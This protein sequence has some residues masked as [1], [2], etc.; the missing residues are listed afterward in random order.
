MRYTQRNTVV[1]GIGD[2]SDDYEYWL[3]FQKPLRPDDQIDLTE[4]ELAEEITKQLDTEHKNFPKNLV[5]YSFKDYGYVPVSFQPV[6]LIK[7]RL[8]MIFSL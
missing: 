8:Q 7:I 2:K 5:I 1:D 3:R 6:I 4:A